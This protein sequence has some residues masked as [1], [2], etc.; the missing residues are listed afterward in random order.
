MH[1]V[2][3]IV[4]LNAKREADTKRQAEEAADER[5]HIANWQAQ[6]ASHKPEFNQVQ[7]QKVSQGQ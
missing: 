3:M 4:A 6:E 5:Q 2:E 1:G 7:T